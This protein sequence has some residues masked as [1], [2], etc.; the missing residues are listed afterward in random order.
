MSRP[1]TTIAALVLLFI[2]GVQAV[3]AYLA[4]DVVID[5]FHVPVI[6]SWAAAGLLGLLALL[7]L[8]EARR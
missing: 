7:T 2:A 3:R 5:G 1:F 4:F 6:A 8:A